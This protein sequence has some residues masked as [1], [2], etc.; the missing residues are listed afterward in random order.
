[1]TQD[2]AKAFGIEIPKSPEKKDMDRPDK[3]KIHRSEDKKLE[4]R[5][6]LNRKLLKGRI[7]PTLPD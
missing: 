3:T 7:L 6:R 1:M 5:A 2:D 4:M